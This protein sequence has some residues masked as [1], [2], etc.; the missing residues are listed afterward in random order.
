MSGKFCPRWKRDD[1]LESDCQV[2]FI[3]CTLIA[4]C[5]TQRTRILGGQRVAWTRS[6]D[7]WRHGYG[8]IFLR[9]LKGWHWIR[10]TQLHEDA[11]RYR[12]KRCRCAGHAAD[13]SPKPAA[14]GW[15]SVDLLRLAGGVSQHLT[16]ESFALTNGVR[17][18]SG[19]QRPSHLAAMVV[20]SMALLHREVPVSK[21]PGRDL[22]KLFHEQQM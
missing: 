8:W 15:F 7:V 20:D 14:A 2:P 19:T 13:S 4:E 21:E 18:I 10:D 11:H 17:D 6:A 22:P 12:G 16:G 1:S 5:A 9:C 3:L